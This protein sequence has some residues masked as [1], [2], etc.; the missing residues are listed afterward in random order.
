M[1]RPQP[2]TGMYWLR[3]RVP[4]DLRAKLGKSEEKKSLKIEDPQAA[5]TRLA[6]QS[7]RLDFVAL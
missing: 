2:K 7:E 4:D 6:L 3:K 1:T 5:K